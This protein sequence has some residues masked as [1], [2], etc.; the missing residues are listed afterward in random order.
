MIA[1]DH[2]QLARA[3]AAQAL[4]RLVRPAAVDRGVVA[5][6]LDDYDG[7]VRSVR[8]VPACRRGDSTMAVR[9]NPTY[10]VG[11]RTSYNGILC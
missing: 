8:Y 1:G 10:N 7:A 5:L 2:L 6:L 3:Q 4:K 11:S 9:G